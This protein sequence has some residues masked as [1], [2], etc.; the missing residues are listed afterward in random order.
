MPY[1]VNLTA[2]SPEK[3][4]RGILILRTLLGVFYVG[5]PHGICLAVYGLAVFFVTI[6][7]W[8]SVLFT[9]QYPKDL[10]NLVVGYKR[11]EARVRAYMLFLTDE[12]PPF[13]GAE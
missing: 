6:A 10:Y 11:W 7:A 2:E 5:V 13:S 3:L 4:S 1:P 12:Y 8:F 9:G